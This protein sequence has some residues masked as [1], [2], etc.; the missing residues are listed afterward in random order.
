MIT[1]HKE[2]MY[3]WTITAGY[4]HIHLESSSETW[5]MW[6]ALIIYAANWIGSILETGE[7]GMTDKQKEFAFVEN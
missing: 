7:C 3:G 1:D 5:K 4:H 6:A 2:V